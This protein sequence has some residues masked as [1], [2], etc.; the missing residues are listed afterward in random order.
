MIFVVACEGKEGIE[1]V[2]AFTSEPVA[3]RAVSLMEGEALAKFGAQRG[4]KIY[5]TTIRQR[6]RVAAETK[7][8]KKER[9][10]SKEVDIELYNS[11]NAALTSGEER[12]VTKE[13]TMRLYD[14]FTIDPDALTQA[15]QAA[16]GTGTFQATWNAKTAG[17]D[18]T[19]KG[20]P[21]KAKP[22]GNSGANA[23]RPQ[24][25]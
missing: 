11:C 9:Q 20:A 17:F 14:Y 24:V 21:R 23:T 2:G 6:Y 22:N 8:V 4:Y 1:I 10:P 15:Y 16:I 3:E 12:V 19:L 18:F 5:P 25:R 7:K 13:E